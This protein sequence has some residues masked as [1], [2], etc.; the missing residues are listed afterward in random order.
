MTMK[1]ESITEADIYKLIKQMLGFP[2]PQICRHD[3][4]CRL[5]SLLE[6]RGYPIDEE[7]VKAVVAADDET[8]LSLLPKNV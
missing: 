1:S 7:F 2:F 5:I 3:V 8:A 4:A 6:E